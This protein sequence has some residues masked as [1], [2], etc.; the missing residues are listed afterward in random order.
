MQLSRS[1]MAVGLISV[2]LRYMHTPNE[3]M[4]LKDLDNAAKLVAA[5]IQRLDPKIDWTP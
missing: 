2:P 4:S 1:G 3:I 5:F